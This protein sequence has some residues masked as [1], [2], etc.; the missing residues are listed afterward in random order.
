MNNEKMVE[1]KEGV[2]EGDEVVLNI[3]DLE[4]S[5]SEKGGES[6]DPTKGKGKGGPPAAGAPGMG[7]AGGAPGGGPP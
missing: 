2:V 6:A 5:K 7:G 4:A 3:R 1:I